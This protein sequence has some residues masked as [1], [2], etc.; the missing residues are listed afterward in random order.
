[1]VKPKVTEGL[2]CPPDIIPVR[3]TASHTVAATAMGF[4]LDI[5]KAQTKRKVPKNSAHALMIRFGLVAIFY[6]W[7]ILL[8]ND[9]Y[10]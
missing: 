3:W 4:P 5:P 7:I 8:L 6:G 9:P 1:M 10:S 2:N